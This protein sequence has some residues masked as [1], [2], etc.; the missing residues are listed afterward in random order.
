M[1]TQQDIKNLIE[2]MQEVFATKDELNELRSDF[3]GLQNSMD[4]IAKQFGDFQVEMRAMN[5]RVTRLEK[6]T[7]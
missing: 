2:A 5:S 4:C 3:R 6:H 7:E 1:L